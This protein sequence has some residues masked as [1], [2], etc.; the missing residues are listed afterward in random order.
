MHNTAY[1]LRIRDWSSDVFSSDLL[2]RT[3]SDRL[4]LITQLQG[5]KEHH[6]VVFVGPQHALLPLRTGQL[7]EVQAVSSRGRDRALERRI[8]DI[9]APSFGLRAELARP[10]AIDAGRRSGRS[11]EGRVGKEGGSTCESRWVPYL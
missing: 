5:A 7:D 6:P 8:V 3:V 11:E 1:E 10:A 9:I 4:A 2:V